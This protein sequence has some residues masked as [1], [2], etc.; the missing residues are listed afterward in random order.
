M[1]PWPGYRAPTGSA[2]ADPVGEGE[3]VSSSGTGRHDDHGPKDQRY[4]PASTSMTFD[5][6]DPH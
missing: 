1:R 5:S 3:V 2:I 6:K 4:V